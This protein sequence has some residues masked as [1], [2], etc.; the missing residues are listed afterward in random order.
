M[1]DVI[2]GWPPADSPFAPSGTRPLAS[3]EEL[4]RERIVAGQAL[5]RAMCHVGT[6]AQIPELWSAVC[7]AEVSLLSDDRYPEDYLERVIVGEERARHSPGSDPD[8]TYCTGCTLPAPRLHQ[9]VR[10]A[11]AAGVPRQGR[12]DADVR[13]AGSRRRQVVATVADGVA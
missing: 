2:A 4:I 10:R 7:A 5:M 8:C 6:S 13:D 9:S 12:P 1:T 3:Y 11:G